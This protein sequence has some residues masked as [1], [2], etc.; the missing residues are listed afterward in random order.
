MTSYLLVRSCKKKALE[1]LRQKRLW[2]PLSLVFALLELSFVGLFF[3]FLAVERI[4]KI[5]DDIGLFALLLALTVFLFLLAPLF[6]GLQMFFLHGLLF[7][8]TETSLFFYCY[9]HKKRY[10][11]ALRK[12]SREL[13]LFLACAT[14]FFAVA[15]SG[16]YV[17]EHFLS[18]DS[19]S[20]LLA[21]LITVLFLL[22]VLF[23]HTVFRSNCFLLDAVFLSAPLLSFR[24]SK[25]LSAKQVKRKREALRRFRRSF[26]PLWLLAIL[27]LGLPLAAILPYYTAAKAHLAVALIQ[28]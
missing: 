19:F 13:F 3:A 1:A 24:Q 26:F 5:Q 18:A 6:C 2:F 27:C 9:S 11:F 7:K 15:V 21:L 12:Y 22:L 17:A 8:R 28:D 10:A 20:A 23:L 25:I 14:L 16:M 4:F